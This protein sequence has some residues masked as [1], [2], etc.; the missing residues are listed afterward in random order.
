MEM[1]EV[2]GVVTLLV[3]GF[4]PLLTIN[5]LINAQKSVKKEAPVKTNMTKRAKFVQFAMFN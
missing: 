4:A 5:T 2:L 1:R 3:I